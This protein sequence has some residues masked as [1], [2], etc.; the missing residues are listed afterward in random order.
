[1][2]DK[3][4]NVTVHSTPS[5]AQFLW[6]MMVNVAPTDDLNMRLALKHCVDRQAMVDSLL[7]GHGTIG[8]DFSVNPRAAMYC[9]EIP[10]NDYDP[11]K[12]RLYWK[13]TGL[14]GI[15]VFVSNAAGDFAVDATV[16]L[17]ESAKKAA[18]IEI[19]VNR[20]PDDGYWDSTWMKVPMFASN[21]NSRPTADLMLTLVYHSKAEWN[22]TQWKNER[23]DELLVLG[24]KTTDPAKRYEIYCEAETLLHDDAAAV[25]ATPLS[26]FLGI[27][28]ALYRETLYDK[29]ISMSTL[30]TISFP[31]F[32]S[33]TSSSP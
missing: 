1:M 12:A 28:A 3:D 8:N 24:R 19:K 30:M 21:W 2:L 20:Q 33:P 9:K 5:G 22:E 16:L 32:L 10:Q 15:E 7:Q 18:G 14:S 17:K 11:D 25:V 4:P 31:D 29:V 13:K 26:V 23:F 6:A 27:L